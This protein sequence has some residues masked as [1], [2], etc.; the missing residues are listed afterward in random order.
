VKKT[1]R[2]LSVFII[3]SLFIGIA[4]TVRAGET[5]KININTAS[6]KELTQLD[7]VGPAKA[8]EIVKYREENGP[9]GSPEDLMKVKG[10]GT[11][12]FERNKD[13]IAA[14][15]PEQKV[16]EETKGSEES[17]KKVS[18][19]TKASEES[20]QKVSEE[21]KTSEKEKVSKEKKS[22]EGKESSEE[23]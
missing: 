6:E 5:E 21:T 15:A 13:R 4:G 9:F 10:I 17:D 2:A 22:S 1:N 3:L 19:E 16:S 7:G 20:E 23:E 12:L 8:A 18:E 11:K 14:G